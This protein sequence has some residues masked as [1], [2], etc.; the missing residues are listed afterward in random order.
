MT[1][2]CDLP[3]LLWRSSPAYSIKC[4]SISRAHV[5]GVMGTVSRMNDHGRRIEDQLPDSQP[6]FPDSNSAG[7]DHEGGT[8]VAKPYRWVNIGSTTAPIPAL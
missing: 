6:V 4:K 8:Q 2:R 7:S 3:P 1:E 5:H